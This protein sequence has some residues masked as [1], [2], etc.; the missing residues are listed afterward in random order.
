MDQLLVSRMAGGQPE[1][2]SSIQGEGVSAGIPSTF[3]RLAVCNLRCSWCD[4]A[5]TWDW[6]HYDRAEQ[7]LPMA[8]EDVVANVTARAPRNVVIT[9]G[10]PLIQRRQLVPL[11]TRLKDEGFRIEVETNGTIAPGALAPLVDQ[12]NVS[13]K[14]AHSGNEGLRRINPASLREFAACERAIFKFVV[15]SEGDLAEVE[16]LREAY[17]IPAGRMVLMPEGRTAAELTARSRWLAEL[18]AERGYRFSTRL[19]IYIWGDKR[20]V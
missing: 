20:G 6:S 3:V 1:I 16:D 11:A 13:P 7:V 8:A 18:C 2:F 10:E 5:Y 4:T 19:H 15:Q 14:L 17:G 9:G 12:W